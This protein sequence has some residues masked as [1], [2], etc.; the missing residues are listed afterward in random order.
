MTFPSLD[1][2]V[3]HLVRTNQ[4]EEENRDKVR[5]ALLHRHRHHSTKKDTDKKS[6]FPTIRSIGDMVS[7]QTKKEERNSSVNSHNGLLGWLGRQNSNS[8]S[9]NNNKQ[10]LPDTTPDSGKRSSFHN[11]N[12][13]GNHDDSHYNV[14]HCT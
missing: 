14:S 5:V 2:V 4:L 6:R 3:D 11:D 10:Q 8:N 12:H 1:I 9:D 13:K 7:N